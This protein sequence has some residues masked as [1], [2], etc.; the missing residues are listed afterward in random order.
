MTNVDARLTALRDALGD[1]WGGLAFR[2]GISRSMLG[3]LRSGR[4]PASRR[5][6]SRIDALEKS[7]KPADGKNANEAMKQELIDSL[8]ECIDAQLGLIEAQAEWIEQLEARIAQM[9]KKVAQAVAWEP[10]QVYHPL[11]GR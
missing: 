11:V 2:L 5:L 10:P 7:A 9:E 4:K 8:R 1:D 6:L 3:F